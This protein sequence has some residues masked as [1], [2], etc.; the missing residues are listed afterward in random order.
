MEI[1]RTRP[2]SPSTPLAE[3]AHDGK[4]PSLA[5]HSVAASGR[6]RDRRVRGPGG[7]ARVDVRFDGE[8]V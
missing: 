3:A 8:T 7:E 2:D 1:W 5:P 4:R 6:R